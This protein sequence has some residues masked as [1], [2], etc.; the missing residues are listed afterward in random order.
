MI[1]KIKGK[2]TKVDK[3]LCRKA[4]EFYGKEL[5]GILYSKIEVKVVFEKQMKDCGFCVWEDTNHRAREFTI[6]IGSNLSGKQTLLTL[7]HEMVH[8]KQY[9]KGEMREYLRSNKSNWKGKIFD[10]DIID[11]WDHEWEWEAYGR[12]RGLYMKFLQTLK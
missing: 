4:V 1:I 9:A 8:V 11:Y 3:S 5:L 10:C 7:A 2:P 12:E 6:S